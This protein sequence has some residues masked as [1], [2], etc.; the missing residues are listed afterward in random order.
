MKKYL[1][2]LATLFLVILLASSNASAFTPPGL[3][4][5]GGL[6]PGIQKKFIQ[7]EKDKKEYNTTIKDINLEQRRIVIE[8]GTAILALLVSDEAKIELNK[9]SAK[10]EDIMKNDDVFMK[11]DKN[12]TIIELKATREKQTVYTVEGRLSLVD[13]KE[14][15]IYIYENNK[16]DSYK[17]KSDVIVRINGVK[18]GIS[19][20]TTGMELKLTIEGDR[21]TLIEASKDVQ[22][23]INGTIIAIDYNRMEFVLQEGTKVTLYKAQSNTPI[24]VDGEI[25]TISNL[26]VGMTLEAYVKDQN[27]ISIEGKSLSI[28]NQ[29]GVVKAINIDKNEI[30][31]KQGNK[32]TLFKINKN[33]VVK[34]N[35]VQ[36]NLRDI[37]VNMDV[38]LTIQSG[39]V[40]EITIN[41]LIQSFEGRIISKDVGNKPTIT[42]QIGNEVKVFSVRKDLNIIEIEVGKDVIIH[43]KDSEV[44]AIVAK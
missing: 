18:S 41:D 7:Q 36:K 20:L 21:V 14:N 43:V 32:E 19:S 9:K 1:T 25:K 35:G 28:E 4:K 2:S 15:K 10:L 39:E 34:I 23:K 27:I 3:A 44:I 11:L 26:L 17:L 31:L 38:E 42:I 29:K 5:K 40:I 13:N 24:K 16:L 8:D 30:V 6:P 22:T 37:A 33:V 12:N